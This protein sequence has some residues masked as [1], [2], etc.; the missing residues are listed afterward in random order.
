MSTIRVF[1][2]PCQRDNR[3][4]EKDIVLRV[5][6]QN[7][8]DA[9]YRYLCAHCGRIQVQPCVSVKIAQLLVQYG[10]RTEWFDLPLELEEKHDHPPITLDDMADFRR[11]LETL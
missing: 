2:E 3:L 1:C 11:E 7:E 5:C 6:R 10:V 4:N 9:Q 8:L